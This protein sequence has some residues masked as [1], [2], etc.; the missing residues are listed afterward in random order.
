[1]QFGKSLRVTRSSFRSSDRRAVFY[2]RDLLRPLGRGPVAGI[3][4]HGAF[5]LGVAG[6]PPEVPR[7][8]K[9][10]KKE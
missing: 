3:F 7:F 9:K 2:L 4:V 8:R 6:A 1:M 10:R 5:T